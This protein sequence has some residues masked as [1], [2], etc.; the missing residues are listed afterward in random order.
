MERDRCKKK[1]WHFDPG[2]SA[3]HTNNA[4]KETQ[5]IKGFLN[6]YLSFAGNVH[7]II[8]RTIKEIFGPHFLFKLMEE[9]RIKFRDPDYSKERSVFMDATMD[10]LGWLVWGGPGHFPSL[11]Q[12][13]L[14]H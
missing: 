12:K 11:Q 3:I 2:I 8:N 9:D 4:L 5:K 7:S 10:R 6:Y 13:L 1:H 14:Q